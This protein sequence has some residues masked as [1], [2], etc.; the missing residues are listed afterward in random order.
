MERDFLAD[1]RAYLDRAQG[2]LDTLHVT[3]T[4]L[5]NTSDVS[6]TNGQTYDGT[7]TLGADV[8]LTASLVTFNDQIVGGGNTLDIAGNAVFGESC[9]KHGHLDLDQ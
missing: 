3:G 4:S 2:G 6:S 9:P 7:V 5:I 1:A 8:T